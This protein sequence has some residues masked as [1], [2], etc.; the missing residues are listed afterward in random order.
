[1]GDPGRHQ[2]GGAVAVDGDAGNVEARQDAD[3]PA[4]VVALLTA[5]QAAAAND[6]LDLGALQLR[7]L[8]HDLPQHVG[9]E[10]VGT[11]VDE[12]A[13]ASPADGRPPVRND[14]RFTHGFNSTSA[15][16]SA[17]RAQT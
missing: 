7:H 12:G 16:H 10:V 4:D 11:D 15:R 9:R 14:D 13:L 6:V 1:G 17:S 2:R 8:V 5:R 3:D